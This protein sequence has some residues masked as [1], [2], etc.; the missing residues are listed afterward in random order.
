[1]LG[2]GS[3]Q[4]ND[5]EKNAMG[6]TFEVEIGGTTVLIEVRPAMTDDEASRAVFMLS[7][8][9]NPSEVQ[10]V[11]ESFASVFERRLSLH[12]ISRVGHVRPRLAA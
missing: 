4:K 11:A 10:Q 7:T 1:M 3:N 5:G 2:D 8:C 12:R 6:T 9:E